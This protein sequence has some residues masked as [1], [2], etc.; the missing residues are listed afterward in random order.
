MLLEYTSAST[1]RGRGHETSL[2][3]DD[4]TDDTTIIA[5]TNT[6]TLRQKLKLHPTRRGIFTGWIITWD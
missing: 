3:N 1:F 6:P 2:Q 4:H 5:K